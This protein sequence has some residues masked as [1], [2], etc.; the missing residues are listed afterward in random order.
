MV[1]LNVITRRQKAIK[2]PK[3]TNIR[4]SIFKFEIGPFVVWRIITDEISFIQFAFYK[5]LNFA[6]SG[7]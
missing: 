4:F 1:F 3:K 7:F 5:N 2:T 6:I